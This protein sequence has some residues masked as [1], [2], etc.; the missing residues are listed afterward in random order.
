NQP[1]VDPRRIEKPSQPVVLQKSPLPN[2]GN[3]PIVRRVKEERKLPPPVAT[4][5]P[6]IET[7]KSS[8]FAKPPLRRTQ[9]NVNLDG[10][11]RGNFVLVFLAIGLPIC[12]LTVIFAVLHASKKRKEELM[13]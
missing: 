11:N 7:E 8:Q 5:S 6:A 10:W 13:A 2:H 12:L 4:P 9:P 1:E 3:K